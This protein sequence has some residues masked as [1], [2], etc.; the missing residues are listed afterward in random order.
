MRCSNSGAAVVCALLATMLLRADAMQNATATRVMT[1]RL[2]N[3]ISVD[4][5]R[6][7]VVGAP[8]V[9]ST[10][11][12]PAVEFDGAHDG[13]FVAANP[14]RGLRQF[15][16][17]IIF[18]PAAGGAEEQRFLH[19]EEAGS[20]N[21]ALIELRLEDDRWS[22][23]TFLRSGETGVTLLDRAKTHAADQWHVA[24]L[25]YDGATMTHYV[26]GVRELTGQIAFAPLG[27]GRTS[28]GVRQNRVSWFKGRIHSVRIA[29]AVEPPAIPL[30]PEGVPGAKADGG[31]ERLE[32]GRVYNVQVPALV[33]VPPGGPSTGT[34]VIV[35]PGG[36][37]ARLAMSNEAAGVASRMQAIGVST[38]ILKYRLAEYGQPAPLQDVLRAVRL[39][40]SRASE[41]GVRPDRIG[42]MGASAGGH[43]A[44]SAATMF[45][46]PE[47]RTGAA[48]DAVNA[49]PDFVALLY[50]VITMAA[51]VAHD[52]SRRNLLGA[53]PS[54]ALVERW[55]LEKQVRPDMP[56]VFL[57]HT[58]EDQSVPLEN[59]LLL[60]QAMRR[61]GVAAE[62]HL[63]ERGPHGFG[64]RTDLG[65]TSGWAD[66]WIDWMRARGFLDK[67]E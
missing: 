65:T 52:D 43:V 33:H 34:A 9:V 66:R 24:T 54:P 53:A 41:L 30:W 60:Y 23:D 29:N 1:W 61:A 48:L 42:V 3:L 28:I 57:A 31:D 35:C 59:S 64:V 27:E 14:L 12:G 62:I 26:D 44:A 50:P 25:T 8:R 4:G 22:L 13:L 20:A 67:Q 17:E 36:G 56:P 45:D 11:R 40:R 2:D 55:S 5:H 49:L 37:Y 15:T 21:R 38:F 18:Q 58:A 51:P 32:D 39:V 16:I 19:I 7:E 46:A 63:Y 10:A 6:L 47:G